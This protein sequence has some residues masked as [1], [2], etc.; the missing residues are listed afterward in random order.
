MKASPQAL[1]HRLLASSLCC[2]LLL[3]PLVAASA[4]VEVRVS[5]VRDARGKIN[6]ALC[7]KERFLKACAYSATAPAQTGE[8][9]VAIKDVP[10]GTFAVLAYQD[11]NE[12]GQLDRNALGVPSER[13]GF[14]RAARGKFGPPGFQEAAIEI[15]EE[16]L[17]TTVRL[18]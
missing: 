15:G 18:R 5:G 16:P 4:T 14:S 12:N 10:A 17:V 3:A 13:Y 1:S 2:A 11:V 7:D 9:T 8:T 6:V